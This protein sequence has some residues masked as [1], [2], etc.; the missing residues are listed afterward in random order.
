MGIGWPWPFQLR[1]CLALLAALSP[2]ILITRYGLLS[3]S[4]RSG[5]IKVEDGSIQPWRLQGGPAKDRRA[6]GFP[7]FSGVYPHLAVYNTYGECGI[8]G[9]V[10]WAERLWIMT[11]PPCEWHGSSDGLYE[12]DVSLNITRR[13]E[14]VGGTHANRLI[15]RETDQLIMGPYVIAKD[16]TVRSI[17]PAIMPGRLTATARHLSMPATHVFFVSMEEGLYSVDVRSLNVTRLLQDGRT[18]DP[19]VLGP[20]YPGWHAKGACSS[21]GRLII[22]NNGESPDATNSQ[23]TVPGPAGVLVEASQTG[24]GDAGSPMRF[25]VIARHQF[26]EV[27]TSGGIYGE[28]E[29]VWVTGWDHRSVILKVRDVQPEHPTPIGV[30]RTYR[31]PKASHTYDGKHGWH[32]EWPRIRPLG[33]PPPSPSSA[34]PYLM[35]MHGTFWHFPPRFHPKSSGG[36]RPLSSYVKMVVDWTVMDGEAVF[37]CDDASK[38][39]NPLVGQSNSNI[40]FVSP[41]KLL[42]GEVG[43]P[44]EG[45]GAVWL[46]EPPTTDPLDFATSG[47]EKDGVSVP[48]LFAGYERRMVHVSHNSPHALLFTFEVDKAGDNKW[49]AL[50][51]LRVEKASERRRYGHLIFDAAAK[52]EWVRARVRDED[53]GEE[54]CGGCNV[55]VFFHHS[56]SSATREALQSDT[57][58]LFASIP[59]VNDVLTSEGLVMSY[60]VIRPRGGNRRT[61]EYAGRTITS[62][63]PI[64]PSLP[65]WSSYY[66]I[67]ADMKLLRKNDSAALSQLTK[68]GDVRASLKGSAVSTFR[69]ILAD[70][71]SPDGPRDFLIDKGSILLVN[72]RGERF[73]LPAGDP[74]WEKEELSGLYGR[75][76]RE[77]VTERFLLNAAGTFFEVPREISGGLALMKPISTHNRLIYDYCSWRGMLVLSG[78]VLSTATTNSPIV[79]SQDGSSGAL[80]FGVVDD[81]WRLGKPVGRGGP[82][83]DSSVQ[84]GVP[85]D[86]FLMYGYDKKALSLSCNEA[87]GDQPLEVRIEV[88]VAGTGVWDEFTTVTVPAGIQGREVALPEGYVARWVRFVSNRD[89][90]GVTAE[91]VYT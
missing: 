13:K 71:T 26:T 73:R 90:A 56:A 39:Q 38:L 89:A 34:P 88:D 78:L 21:G 11:Y 82:W 48:F 51:T 54:G 60:G 59:T 74:L 27:A 55:T 8:G 87:A 3:L 85:S 40:W 19:P 22:A 75:G 32:T 10:N 65:P 46:N 72:Q 23:W 79:T 4:G 61:L 43:G 31:L 50:D 36:L 29:G 64:P 5:S 80:W 83:K 84:K 15:H 24:E 28:G 62:P 66:E 14:S 47:D 69:G 20:W 35:T 17:D 52:G 86:P 70:Q 45:G 9:I 30:Y 58:G 41:Q 57:E 12:I 77:V 2:L 33:D 53:T 25:D 91:M 37:A 67:G 16:G 81:L 1:G 42:S 76:F 68:V 63:A 7:R 44:R 49:E 18:L 6:L